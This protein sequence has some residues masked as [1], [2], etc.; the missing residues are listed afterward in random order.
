[1]RRSD[2]DTIE[3]FAD[4]SQGERGPEHAT[5]AGVDPGSLGM[6]WRLSLEPPPATNPASGF[7]SG[8]LTEPLGPAQK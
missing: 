4:P 6:S 7:G 8:F 5:E 1:M 3:L 2:R